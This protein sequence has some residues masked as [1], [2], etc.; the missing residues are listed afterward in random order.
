MWPSSAAIIPGID[1]WLG[2]Y[3]RWCSDGL[4]FS[5]CAA[6]IRAVTGCWWTTFAAQVVVLT[7]L[8]AP[9]R[10]SK[11]PAVCMR[12]SSVRL[13]VCPDQAVIQTQELGS[14]SSNRHTK[15]GGAKG[16]RTPDLLH[17]MQQC[18]LA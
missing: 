12:H 17:A 16:I 2:R 3:R 14:F 15:N 1:D 10:H 8:A 4:S 9:G 5:G 13:S 11:P 6:A 7:L 18:R